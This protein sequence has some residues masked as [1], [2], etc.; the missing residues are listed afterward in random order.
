MKILQFPGTSDEEKQRVLV[1]KQKREIA[2]QAKIIEQ[3]KRRARDI[4]AR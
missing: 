1:L 2:D 4:E 3:L